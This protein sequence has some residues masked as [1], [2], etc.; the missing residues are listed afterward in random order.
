MQIHLK[1]LNQELLWLV[2]IL[3]PNCI[4][5]RVTTSI[6]GTNTTWQGSWFSLTVVVAVTALLEVVVT[7]ADVPLSRFVQLRHQVEPDR[8]LVT[9]V[10]TAHAWLHS[11]AVQHNHES[12]NKETRLQREDEAYSNTWVHFSACGLVRP[13]FFMD[14]IRFASPPPSSAFALDSLM[15]EHNKRYSLTKG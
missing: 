12:S 13:R 5:I 11:C 15:S 1:S 2:V 8:H 9:A 4:P 3:L 14:R 7:H 6:S 10:V